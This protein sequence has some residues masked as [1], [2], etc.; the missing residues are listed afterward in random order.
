MKRVTSL[1][2]QAKYHKDF[3]VSG[4][5]GVTQGMCGTYVVRSQTTPNN[6][7]VAN[8]THKAVHQYIMEMDRRPGVIVGKFSTHTYSTPHPPFFYCNELGV[9]LLNC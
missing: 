5:Q 2:L 3:E 9:T 7:T 4:L 1:F 8:S 6:E